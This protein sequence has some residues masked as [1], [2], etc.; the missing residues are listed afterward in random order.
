VAF[1]GTQTVVVVVN[2]NPTSK[3]QTFTFKN[4]SV[5]RVMKYTTSAIKNLRYEG[6]IDVTDSS[7]TTTLDSASITTFVSTK[8]IDC[9]QT[10]IIPYLQVNNGKMIGTNKVICIFGD[11]IILAPQAGSDSSWSWTGCGTSGSWNTQTINPDGTCTSV[12][13]TYT[14]NCGASTSLQYNI[15]VNPKVAVNTAVLSPEII[16]F[17]NPSI[18]G[19]FKIKAPDNFVRNTINIF[20]LVGEQVY[21]N[22]L[23]G[24][25]T[26]INSGLKPGIYIIK[27]AGKG[28]SFSEKLILK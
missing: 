27:I 8:T 9:P 7:F 6:T 1:K 11:S 16:V 23:R 22:S 17:P 28:S 21:T 14:N 26:T 25:E 20:N 2:I 19:T 18:S 10:P 24:N 4:D 15:T 13:A 5:T 12:I 3:A